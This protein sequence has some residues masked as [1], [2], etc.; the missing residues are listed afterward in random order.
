V[1]RST[2]YSGS[3]GTPDVAIKPES[4]GRHHS[5]TRSSAMGAAIWVS[6]GV[7]RPSLALDATPRNIVRTLSVNIERNLVESQQEYFGLAAI[8]K[9]L[10]RNTCHSGPLKSPS[11]VGCLG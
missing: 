5:P 10:D 4:K 3:P 9:C 2:I 7:V 8:P 1:I 11:S 6:A